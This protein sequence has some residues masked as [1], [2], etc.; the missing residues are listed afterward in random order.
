MPIFRSWDFQQLHSSTQVLATVANHN[1]TLLTQ[2]TIGK[3]QVLT[4][5]T[6]LPEPESTVR[7]LWNEMWISDQFW[8]AFGILRGALRSLSGIDAGGLTYASGATVQL[9]NDTTIWPSRWE[10]YWPDAQR[11]S[12]QSLDGSLMVGQPSDPGIYFL[13][14]T[15]GGPVSRGFSV[16]IPASDTQLTQATTEQLDLL[17]GAGAYR[18]ARDREEVDSSVGQARFGRELYPLMMLFVAALFL[19]EQIMSNRFYQIPLR[20]GKEGA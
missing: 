20:L 13:R 15:M 14:G 2:Q 8:V 7:P 3:G 12:L 11:T 18:I 10:L 4:L 5:T 1:S 17:L 9:S 19:A 6:P 16:N